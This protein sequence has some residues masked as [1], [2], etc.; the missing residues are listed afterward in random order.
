VDH[1]LQ[2][3]TNRG[4]QE[5]NLV[6][7]LLIEP[8][9]SPITLG[10]ED[11]AI[12]EPLALEYVAA[13][14]AQDHDV[15]ILDMRLDKNLSRVLR[16]F[17]PDI[18]G[19]TAYTVHVNTVRDLFATVK[20][21]NPEVLTVVGGHHATIV[22]EDLATPS[23]DLIVRG[24]GVLPFREIVARFERGTEFEGI[25]GI[26]FQKNGRL[27]KADY[28]PATDLDSLPFPERSFTAAYRK[29]YYAEWMR[30]L[31]SIRTSKGCPF[32]C[33]FCALWK[34]AGG[35]YLKRTPEKIVEELA[36]IDE[37]YVFFADDE[38]L[39]DVR[40]MKALARLI[41]ESGLKKQYFLYGRSDT[42]TKNPDLLEQWR[43]VGLERVFVGLEFF[44]EE[45][46][47]FIRK[48]STL[49]DNQSAVRILQDLGIEI[50]ASFIVRPEFTRQDFAELRRYCH[51]L[52]LSFASFG[53]LTPLPG[54]DYFAEVESHLITR[55]Y[56]F[57]DF[58]HTVL[59][60]ELPL[61]EFYAEY[62]NLYRNAV[63]LSR[64]AAV[65][66][67]FPPKEIPAALLKAFRVLVMVRNAYRDY[68]GVGAVGATH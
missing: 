35:R 45:D 40:R 2:R 43:D 21:W 14:V 60:T 30:P 10:G 53:V 65:L 62:S 61:K 44:R 18:V 58:V 31:A 39:V 32:R 47:R 28:A 67:R 56:D 64:S 46:L 4:C 63:P 50:Y 52:D 55:N 7:I 38:S 15:K 25:P 29:H 33:S 24:E 49:G 3:Q 57:F 6:K 22:P 48:G 36:K 11:F 26:A 66:K 8:A 42:I 34:I 16:E 41:K 5:V 12:Y 59:P 68:E 54:T 1:H 37:E 13:G 27:V 23:V 9:K 20:A 17:S 51:E 19:I